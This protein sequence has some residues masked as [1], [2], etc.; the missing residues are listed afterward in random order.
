MFILMALLVFLSGC[1]ESSPVKVGLIADFSGRGSQL[2]PQA[3]NALIMAID[4]INEEGGVLNRP[5]ELI[6]ADHRN[7]PDLA[8]RE[9]LRLID[10]GAVVIFGPMV[11]G[12]ASSVIDAASLSGTL[13]I[14]ATVSTDNLT[15]IDDN[16]IRG[17]A[18]ASY[19][20]LYLAMVIEEMR[21]ENVVFIMD[22][23]NKVY[24]DGVIEGY[25]RHNPDLGKEIAGRFYFHAKEDF[26]ALI[27][28]VR[29]V[30]PDGLVFLASGI[31]SSGIIQLWARD[32]PV[33][34]LFGGSWPK[35]TGIENYAGKLAENMIFIDTPANDIPLEREKQFYG[36]FE[37]IFDAV[38][39]IAAI[40]TYE[41]I[42]FYVRAA[43]ECRSFDSDKVKAAI[44]AMDSI[45]GIYDTYTIDEYGDGIRA[46]G[47]FILNEGVYKKY[48]LRGMP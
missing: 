9:V 21:L 25:A 46:M 3:R 39:N 5:M 43:E 34:Q 10:E 32:N 16:F 19:Q 23:K 36:K 13:V 30:E 42:H 37:E 8:H 29:K 20:G 2:G 24:T 28:N 4:E 35:V 47:A 6:Y 7:D 27:E 12:M 45:E 48:P 1:T 11:S 40:H 33:P 22:G 15:G 31:D 41:S 18:P 38:P 14:A 17:V 26:P 44:I